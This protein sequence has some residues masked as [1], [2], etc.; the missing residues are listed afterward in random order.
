M[1]TRPRR[2]CSLVLIGLL[3]F[4]GVSALATSPDVAELLSLGPATAFAFQERLDRIALDLLRLPGN[5]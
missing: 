5:S 1:D 3:A 2:Y 4:L